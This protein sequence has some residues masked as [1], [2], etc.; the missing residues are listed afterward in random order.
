[1]HLGRFSPSKTVTLPIG[2]TASHACLENNVIM[3]NEVISVATSHK[4][5]GFMISTDLRWTAHKESISAKSNRRAGLLCHMARYHPLRVTEKLHVPYVRPTLEY[6]CPVWHAS[7]TAEQALCPERIQ[8]S[9][10]R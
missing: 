8:V 3:E 4:Y 10:A 9:V 1:M 7:I 6:V 2:K 5:L